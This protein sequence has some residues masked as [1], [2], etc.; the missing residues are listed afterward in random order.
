MTMAPLEFAN[1][2]YSSLEPIYPLEPTEK[3]QI[4]VQSLDQLPTNK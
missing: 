2:D 4:T 3:A 1:T